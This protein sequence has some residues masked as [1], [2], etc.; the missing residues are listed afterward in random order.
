MPVA[1]TPPAVIRRVPQQERSRRRV[2][3]ILDAA[4]RLVVERGVDALTTRDLAAGAGVPVASLYQYFADKDDVLVALAQRDMG[5]MD[6]QVAAD[7]QAL[8]VV[9]VASM[10]RTTMLAFVKVYGRRPAFVEVYLRGRASAT[11]HQFGRAH[12]EQLAHDLR[13]YALDIGIASDDLTLRIAELALEIGDRI[14]QLAYE[15]RL[16]GD[17]ALV[18]EGIVMMTAYLERYATPAGLAGVRR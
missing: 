8:D 16:A 6:T 3:D 2:E 7:L 12:L 18:E 11:L 13:G 9:S 1:G 15:E 14:F 17:E 10:V 4:E 5:E